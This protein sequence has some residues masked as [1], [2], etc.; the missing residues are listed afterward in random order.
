MRVSRQEDKLLCKYISKFWLRQNDVR[1]L[2]KRQGVNLILFQSKAGAFEAE[3]I[4]IAS[5]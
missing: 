5:L 1:F 3:H 4:F 2:S